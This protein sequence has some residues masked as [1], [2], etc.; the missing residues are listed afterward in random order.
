MLHCADVQFTFCILNILLQ[1]RQIL[2]RVLLPQRLPAE[3]GLEVLLR[4]V[5]AVYVLQVVATL[6][7]PVAGVLLLLAFALSAAHFA[8]LGWLVGSLLQRRSL[9]LALE[10]AVFVNGFVLPFRVVHLRLFSLRQLLLLLALLDQMLLLLLK[11]LEQLLLLEQ[12][13]LLLR[14][15]GWI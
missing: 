4:E 13:L 9:I 5:G 2:V 3:L 6:V 10:G 12:N 8:L 15:L 1:L 7:L 11:L 14:F